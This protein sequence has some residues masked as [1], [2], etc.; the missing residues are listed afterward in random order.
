MGPEALAQVL[1]PLSAMVPKEHASSLISGL[2]DGDDAA[3][4]RLDSDTC[5]V[6]TA[7]FFTPVVDDPY[8]YG[9]IAAANALSDVYATGGKPLMALNLAAFP[10]ELP[11]ET[12]GEILRGGVEKA[13]E[14]GCLVAGGH[15]VVDREP[16][17]GMAVVGLASPASVLLKSGAR[18]GDLLVLGKAL[19]TGVITTAAKQGACPG[20]VLAGA[21]ASMKQLNQDALLV[22]AGHGA[23]A[24][25]DITGFSF[26]G[27]ALELAI[28]GGVGLRIFARALRYLDGTA[29]LVAEGHLPGGALR[30][31]RYYSPA[32]EFDQGLSEDFRALF[33]VPETSGG[34]LAAIPRE[35]AE[36]C[37]AGLI[38]A[39]YDATVA[40]EV[41]EGGPG[42]T[43]TVLDGAG[44]W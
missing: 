22:M 35:K 10:P 12:I 2:E 6:F 4:Y 23:R 36:S 8:D 27:H 9:A 13:A 11:P 20:E 34:L 1:R 15:T 17:F 30:N 39:G 3:V 44:H 5:L 43:M 28:K 40:G 41:L 18:P 31:R 33:F 7:D 25:T 19:G 29:G 42:P 32:I 24:M 38:E 26:A 16:K 37:L 14:A 21:V